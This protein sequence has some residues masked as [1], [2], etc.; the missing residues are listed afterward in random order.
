M[1]NLPNILTSVRILLVPI[2]VVVLLTKFDGK[3]FVGLGLFLLAALTDFLDGYFARRWNLVSRFG[4]LLDPAADKILIAAAFVSLVELD[5]RVTPSWM[6]VT[7]L[8]REFAVNALRSHAAAEQMVIPAGISGK[9]KT[10]AQIVAISLLI[11]YNQLGEFS[12]LAPI[13]LW[14]AVIVTLYSGFEYFF[15]YWSRLGGGAPGARPPADSPP[16]PPVSA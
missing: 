13:S 10:G 11:I 2:L 5:A 1:T 14:V 7:I 6:V 15:R 3:E 12:H 16:R 8:A 9:I 4:Q